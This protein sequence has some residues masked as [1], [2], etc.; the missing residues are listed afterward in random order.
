M[1]PFEFTFSLFGLLLGLGLAAG[2]GGLARALKS[3]H[4]VRIGWSTSLLALLLSC[5][6]VTFWA[7]A[8]SVREHIPATFPALFYGFIVTG[9]YFVAASLAFPDDPDEWQDLEAH[10]ARHG[11]TVLAGMFVANAMLIGA[12]IKMIGFGPVWFG[13]RTIIITWSFFPLAATAILAKDRRIVLG[14]IVLLILL[15]PLSVVWTG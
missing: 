1:S 7:Y 14:A 3:R 6:L 15:Y 9:I 8:W 4:K 2:L 5:D 11:R 12:T 10:F 13:L